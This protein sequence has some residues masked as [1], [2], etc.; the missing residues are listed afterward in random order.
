MWAAKLDGEGMRLVRACDALCDA[1]RQLGV[2]IDG[3]KDSLSMAAKV[4]GEIVKAPGTL[5]ISAYA[6]CT[7]VTEVV[8][9]DLKGSEDGNASRLI[10]VRFGND[11]SEHRLGASALAQCLKQIG[12]NTAD[13]DD[14]HL[15]KRAFDVT[16]NLV[17][18]RRLISGHDVSDGDPLETLFAEESGIVVETNENQVEDIVEMYRSEGIHAQCIGFTTNDVGRTAMVVVNVN[19]ETALSAPLCELR[20]IWEE[21][22]AQ[23]ELLQTNEECVKQQKHWIRVA[24]PVHYSAH[25]DF[26]SSSNVSSLEQ[27]VFMAIIREEGSNGDREMS[28]AFHMA[29]FTPFDVTMS[30]LVDCEF[31]LERFSGIAFVGGFSFGDVLGSARG[32]ASSILFHGKVFEQLRRFRQRQDTF[33]LGVCNGCQLMAHLGWIGNLNN[34]DSKQN[35]LLKA[36][37]CGRFQS[38]FT[39]VRINRSPSI[40]LSGMHGSVLG[41]WSAHGEGKFTYRNDEVL[42]QMIS[43]ELI[44]V[45]YCDGNG[46]P[47]MIF[48]EN[49]N[50]SIE[51]V[52]A[53]C[54]LDGRHLAM[55]PHP[56][57]S[58]ISWQ[59]PNY[60][61]QFKLSNQ[62]NNSNNNN[63]SPW[64]R[65]FINAY[66]WV[67]QQQ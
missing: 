10:Y 44:C 30:D 27:K 12:N 55:M 31:G 65:M 3:G 43:N 60:P 59:W 56:D 14:V 62:Q 58:F 51:S 32:W 67:K 47:S 21:T 1:M 20:E 41:V 11:G 42:E 25:F 40:M 48:P 4:N 57:R 33:S 8:T 63:N 18:K 52:A 28:A 35:V 6:P 22:S 23:L 7:N 66:E 19:G 50:G 5:V 2:A 37:D 17:K 61:K 64:M 9:P 45:Q 13:I 26:S 16:Q 39:T 38:S 29:G 34:E 36:N 53:I 54:S 46:K 15:F 49:P 24:A